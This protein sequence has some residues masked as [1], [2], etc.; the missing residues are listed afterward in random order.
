MVMGFRV[1]KVPK[2]GLRFFKVYGKWKHDVF[3]FLDE[4]TTE[5][6]C[7]KQF[8]MLLLF[9]LSFVLRKILSRVFGRNRLSWSWVEITFFLVLNSLSH[10]LKYSLQLKKWIVEQVFLGSLVLWHFSCSKEVRV[11]NSWLNDNPSS[12]LH[13]RSNSRWKLAISIMGPIHVVYVW[14]QFKLRYEI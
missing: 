8:L 10:S 1:K 5:K 4:V 14:I 12:Y 2:I 13:G 9:F 6:N 3:I 11:F 7:F